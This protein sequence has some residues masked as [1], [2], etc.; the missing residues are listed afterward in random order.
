M[1][2]CLT[3]WATIRGLNFVK[4]NF[5]DFGWVHNHVTEEAHLFI[6]TVGSP[7]SVSVGK[8]SSNR[9]ADKNLTERSWS[10]VVGGVENLAVGITNV[11]ETFEAVVKEPGRSS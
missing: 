11:Q 5:D 3:K 1:H 6:I 8:A 7:P 2:E 4:V 10:R 9:A